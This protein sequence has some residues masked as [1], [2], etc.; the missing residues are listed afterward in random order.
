MKLFKKLRDKKGMGMPTV[1][2]IVMFTTATAVTL[3]SVTYSQNLRVQ[4]DITKT[5]EY[6]DAV[7]AVKAASK[8]IRDNAQMTPS[9]FTSS[10]EFVITEIH[11]TDWGAELSISYDP[12]TYVVTIN[13][14]VT[15]LV[16]GVTSYLSPNAAVTGSLPTA[17]DEVGDLTNYL[18]PTI[19]PVTGEPDLTNITDVV[20]ESFTAQYADELGIT[21]VDL[22]TTTLVELYVQSLAIENGYTNLDPSI[23]DNI[24]D[25][26]DWVID[27]GD[28]A[29]NPYSTVNSGNEVVIMDDAYV[30]RDFTVN[31]SGEVLLEDGDTMF[32]AGDVTFAGGSDI[33]GGGTF[34]LSEDLKISGGSDVEASFFIEGNVTMN[35]GSTLEIPVG[36]FMYVDGNLTVSGGSYIEGT[37]IVTGNVNFT[38]TVTAPTTMYIGGNFTGSSVNFGTIDRPAFWFVNGTTDISNAPSNTYYK[39]LF[40]Y[41]EFLKTPDWFTLTVTGDV[42]YDTYTGVR[43]TWS[44]AILN[45]TPIDLRSYYSNFYTVLGLPTMTSGSSGGLD[46]TDPITN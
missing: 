10:M 31:G 39:Y 1:L 30:N 13:H 24:T 11:N 12:G 36:S 25:V 28:V 46:S 8:I 17:P 41:T 45:V 40:L 19:D 20:Q 43:K 42:Q 15:A 14:P 44:P 6:F 2:G 34:I 16:N 21:G 38:G 18:S 32:I 23:T 26:I 37:I 7:N 33:E 9:S 35:G 29:A 22:E 27:T 4:N 5:D 3:F